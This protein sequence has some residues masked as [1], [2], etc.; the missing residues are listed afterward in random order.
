MLG[1]GRL[2]ADTLAAGKSARGPVA[3]RGPNEPG[4]EGPAE[5][6]ASMRTVCA[7]LPIANQDGR[8]VG[9]S[10][11]DEIQ[12]EYVFATASKSLNG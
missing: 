9:S 4:L 7:R 3:R 8:S 6:K 12:R 10:R 11:Q 1:V 5:A 2:R